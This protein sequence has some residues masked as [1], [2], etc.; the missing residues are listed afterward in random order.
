MVTRLKNR[1]V[2]VCGGGF[3]AGLIARQLTAKNIDVPVLER[4]YDRTRG[5]EA[6]TSPLSG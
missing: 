4:G 1:T 5:A 2:V 3:T 6:N